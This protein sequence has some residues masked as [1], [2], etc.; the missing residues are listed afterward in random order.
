M[1]T[2]QASGKPYPPKS[3]YAL[4]C[5]LLRIV[6]SNGTKYTNRSLWATATSRMFLNNVPE[7]IIAEKTGHRSLAGLRAYENTTHSQEKAVTKRVSSSN[8]VFTDLCR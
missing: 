4:L 5:G 1:E 6:H 8:G 3:I 2:R 7:K